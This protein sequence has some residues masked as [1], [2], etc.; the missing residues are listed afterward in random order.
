MQMKPLNL[1][2]ADLSLRPSASSPGREEVFDP[3]RQ[4]WVTLTAEERVR[5]LFTAWLVSAKGYRPTRMANEMTIT[6]NGMSRRCD[7]VVFDAAGRRPVAIVEYKAPTVKITAE[8]FGQAA[9][10]NIV[11]RTP[12]LIVSNGLT[13][14]CAVVTIGQPPQFL[15]DI[16]SYEELLAMAGN[17]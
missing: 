17:E 10:Y 1:P 9:R 3:L 5:Q 4:K 8:V 13:H 15:R 14:Y 7:T 16:P 12:L 11:L 6:L 2:P